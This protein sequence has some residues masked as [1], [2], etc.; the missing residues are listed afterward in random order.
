MS[1]NMGDDAAKIQQERLCKLPSITRGELNRHNSVDD[2]WIVVHGVVYDIT[3]YLQDHPGGPEV[4][5]CNAGRDVSSDFEDIGHSLS[6]RKLAEQF[7]VGVLENASNP[8]TGC[9]KNA[10]QKPPKEANSPL[11]HFVPIIVAAAIA[12]LMYFVYSIKSAS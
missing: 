5:L 3:R 6:A 10:R 9:V 4:I 8:V 7:E 1:K 11:N 12:C 2:C